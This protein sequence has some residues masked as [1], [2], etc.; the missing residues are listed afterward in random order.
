MNPCSPLW[1]EATKRS[2]QNPN[3]LSFVHC[4]PPFLGGGVRFCGRSFTLILLR[5]QAL[6]VRNNMRSVGLKVD[7]PAYTAIVTAL[8]AEGRLEKAFRIIGEME[9]DSRSE[10][11]LDLGAYVALITACGKLGQLDRAAEVLTRVRD[12]KVCRRVKKDV[13]PSLSLSRV[14]F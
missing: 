10:D 11:E 13:P 12:L 3:D 4:P 1:E 14:I 6:K 5:L 9:E 7:E 2:V 8:G